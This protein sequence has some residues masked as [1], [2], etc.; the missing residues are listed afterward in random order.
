MIN[1]DILIVIIN[2]QKIP[3]EG[4]NFSWKLMLVIVSGKFTLIPGQ[5]CI[6]RMLIVREPCP[7]RLNRF[8]EFYIFQQHAES[9]SL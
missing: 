4:H 5:W 2:S 1:L 9:I 7:L 8:I 3:N 6:S